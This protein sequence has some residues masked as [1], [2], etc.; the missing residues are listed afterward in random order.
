MKRFVIGLSTGYLLTSL[1]SVPAPS[2]YFWYFLIGV[3]AIIFMLVS[4]WRK[5]NDDLYDGE[6]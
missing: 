4:V 3:G 6:F 1:F 2:A 5:I